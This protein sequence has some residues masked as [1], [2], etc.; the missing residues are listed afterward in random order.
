MA[1]FTIPKVWAWSEILTHSDLNALAAAV[2]ASAN[3]ID[4]SQVP[5]GANLPGAEILDA[6]I[7]GAQVNNG[8]LLP[9]HMQIGA[10]T[11]WVESSETTGA[12][13]AITTSLT[14]VAT[15]NKTMSA[16]G[17]VMLFAGVTGDCFLDG[18]GEFTKIKA[19]LYKDT[20]LIG[21]SGSLRRLTVSKFENEPAGNKHAWS[22]MLFW[23]ELLAP[24]SYTWELK[25][26]A[27]F[28]GST[29]SPTATMRAN[30]FFAIG[31]I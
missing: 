12:S 22:H 30:Q 9:S 20:V 23:F 26:Q 3:D 1:S 25:L 6:T 11:Q 13:T 16:A 10:G 17:L 21:G 18:D 4:D 14:T 19:G 27:E 7:T 29:G 8:A 15:L 31:L 28:S 2:A 5:T 24:S